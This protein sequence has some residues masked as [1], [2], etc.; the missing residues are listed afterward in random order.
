MLSCLE[1]SPLEISS[2]EVE[3]D[4][5]NV[6]GKSTMPQLVNSRGEASSALIHSFFLFFIIFTSRINLIMRRTT[7]FSRIIKTSPLE[8]GHS[9]NCL[10][11]GR[12]AIR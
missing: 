1:I 7:T 9:F 11:K 6:V 5:K 8:G 12:H 3:R 4:G 10:L 2:L